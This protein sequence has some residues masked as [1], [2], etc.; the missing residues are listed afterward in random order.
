M[1]LGRLCVYLT[2]LLAHGHGSLAQYQQDY[3]YVPSTN[4][5]F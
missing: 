4:T 2:A 1:I 3:I 5:M